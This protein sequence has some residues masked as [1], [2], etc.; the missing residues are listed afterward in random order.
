MSLLTEAD[1][2]EY[3]VMRAAITALKAK[4]E[5]VS[6]FLT[7]QAMVPTLT[8]TKTGRMFDYGQIVQIANFVGSWPERNFIEQRKMEYLSKVPFSITKEH[9]NA[10]LLPFGW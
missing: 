3:K 5:E 9:I 7:N 8:I 6:Y 2:M 4:L 10:G 1:E